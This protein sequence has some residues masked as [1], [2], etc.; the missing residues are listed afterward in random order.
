M[1][2]LLN[3]ASYYDPGFDYGTGAGLSFGAIFGLIFGIFLIPALIVYALFSVFYMFLFDK[4]GVQGKWRAWIPV[5]REMIFLKLGDV[6]PWLI[7]F[8]IGG[9]VLTWAFVG[10]LGVLAYT[11]FNL[12]AVVRISQKAKGEAGWVAL[13]AGFPGI[14]SLIWLGIM[15]FSKTQAWDNTVAPSKWSRSGFLSDSTQWS[16]VPSSAAPAAQ[17]DYTAGYAQPGYPAQPGYAAPAAPAAPQPPTYPAAPQAPQT[18]PTAPE[19]PQAD[20]TDP[21][22]P[23]RPPQA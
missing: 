9:L 20:G 6:N 1:I 22:E 10:Y 17:P 18:P 19:A 21:L 23:P 4:A 5:Y 3:A 14:G 16:G 7:F 2:D 11:V 8:F 15:A 13:Y 12:L